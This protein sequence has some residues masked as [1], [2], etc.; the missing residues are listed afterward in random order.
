M[1]ENK[2]TV[3]RIAFKILSK[4]KIIEVTVLLLTLLVLFLFYSFN[5]SIGLLFFIPI[6]LFLA[7]IYFL[8]SFSFPIQE[9]S[10]FLI[11]LRKLSF[12]ALAVVNI[13]IAFFILNFP[14]YK[15]MLSVGGVTLFIAFILY[16]FQIINGK[17]KSPLMLYPFLIRNLVF[18]FFAF[19]IL[20]IS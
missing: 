19:I 13:G 7:V 15:T 5:L 10:P 6:P 20:L 9:V 17:S 1:E 14:N 11:F 3:S 18:V 8:L 12:M 4:I 16:V 2:E